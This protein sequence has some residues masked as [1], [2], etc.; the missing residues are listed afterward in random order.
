MERPNTVAGLQAKRAELAGE[1]TTAEARL[2]ELYASLAHLDGAI[3][4]FDPSY[5]ADLIPPKRP[6][7][8]RELFRHAEL[9]RLVLDILRTATEPMTA[10]AV[11]REIMRRKELPQDGRT[12]RI[13]CKR[14]DR[15][16][17][18]GSGAVAAGSVAGAG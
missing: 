18:G 5:P 8:G 13:V 15:L 7:T 4:L 16:Q 6:P 14:V 9:T 3:R 10:P 1:I 17:A 12:R 11:A 2:G